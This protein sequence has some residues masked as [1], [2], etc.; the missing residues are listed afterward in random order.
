MRVRLLIFLPNIFR[1][2][3]VRKTNNSKFTH[4]MFGKVS[5]KIRRSICRFHLKQKQNII[6]KKLRAVEQLHDI[7]SKNIKIV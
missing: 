2:K 5:S 7:T 4:L 3:S 6:I 1:K